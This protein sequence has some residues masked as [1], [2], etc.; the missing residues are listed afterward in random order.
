MTAAILETDGL[1]PKR[2]LVPEHAVVFLWKSFIYV[3]LGMDN[4]SKLLDG[5]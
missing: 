4:P 2:C 3:D 1:M 5:M